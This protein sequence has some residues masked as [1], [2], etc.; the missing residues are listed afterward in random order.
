MIAK[1]ALLKSPAN[2]AV[3]MQDLSTTSFNGR[4]SGPTLSIL[5]TGILDPKPRPCNPNPTTYN[6]NP[7]RYTLDL[8]PEPYNLNPKTRTLNHTT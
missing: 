8:N 4:P 2:T 6:L 1:R 7:E 3:C 5:F